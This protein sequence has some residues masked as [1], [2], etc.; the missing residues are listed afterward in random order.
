M[1]LHARIEAFLDPARSPKIEGW[2][3]PEKAKAMAE[4]ILK[5]RPPLVVEIGVFGGRSLVPQAMALQELGTGIVVGIDP[6]THEAALE[7]EVGAGNAEWWGKLDLD[8]I[9]KGAWAAVQDEGVAKHA[10]LARAGSEAAAPLFMPGAIGVLHID[11][12]HSELA[13]CRDVELY[14]PL[15]QSGGYIWFDDADW[16]TTQK[17]IT[18]LDGRC[19]RVSVVGTCLLFRKF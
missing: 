7:G 9:A 15:V 16:S 5:H 17:A 6:W 2:T 11:G 10:V 3:T 19:R 14:Y 8:N 13:S 18:L 1:N 4:L 12:N